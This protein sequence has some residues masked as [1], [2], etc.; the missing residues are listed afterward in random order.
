ML[1]PTRIDHIYERHAY[2][3]WGLLAAN[4]LVFVLVL[5]SGTE[6]YGGWWLDPRDLNPLQFLTSMF[7]HAGLFHLAGNLLFLWVFGRYVEERL[8]PARFLAFYALA[9]I[10]GDLLY[11]ALGNENPCVGASGAISGLMGFAF[12]AAPWNE[13]K[14]LWL[15]HPA[16][17]G[18]QGFRGNVDVPVWS[19][20]GLWLGLQ[21]LY[22]WI[23]VWGVAFSAHVGGFAFGVAVAA[24][25]RSSLCEGTPWFLEPAPAGGGPAA[26]RR[27]EKARRR[28]PA[29]TA[30]V[31]EGPAVVLEALAPEG[32][33][34]AVVKLLMKRFWLA[35]EVAKAHVDAL[36]RGEAQRFA[37]ECD[38]Q[39]EQVQREALALGV[40]AR[41]E[42]GAAEA[43]P[44]G[45]AP[46]G[47]RGVAEEP[48][49]APEPLPE[50]PPEKLPPIEFK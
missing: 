46:S 14:V 49:V 28:G 26:R 36:A 11:L 47:T 1:L 50:G 19:L 3:T 25:L 24:V 7:L 29:I 40:R 22:G 16:Q 23:G 30:P 32:S 41:R 38:E 31:P 17:F 44:A 9:G 15:V 34:V 27:L 8:G 18:A 5:A 20:L 13:V 35:P 43:E 4:V 21:L 45:N 12:V 37:A 33:A 39:A 10:A 2:A 48:S 6:D 42:G